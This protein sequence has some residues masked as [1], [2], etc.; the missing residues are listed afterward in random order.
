MT[1][2]VLFQVIRSKSTGSCEG[3]G[4]VRN[5]RDNMLRTEDN[6]NGDDK[7]ENGIGQEND[8]FSIEMLK[9]MFKL[10]T[11]SSK[12]SSKSSLDDSDDDFYPELFGLLDNPG[13]V[14]FGDIDYPLAVTEDSHDE[15]LADTDPAWYNLK[16]VDSEKGIIHGS[17]DDISNRFGDEGRGDTSVI[18]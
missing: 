2:I 6:N 8:G 9:T 5:I 11:E 7:A 16:D 12:C 1:K 13:V 18:L 4:F 14:R 17:I 15:G 3:K 10:D